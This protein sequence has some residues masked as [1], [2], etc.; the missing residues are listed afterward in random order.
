[1]SVAYAQ[2]VRLD[3]V[4]Q[5]HDRGYVIIPGIMPRTKVEA[6]ASDLKDRFARTPFCE[7]EFYGSHT[8]RF[9]GLLKRSPHAAAFVQNAV[10]MD[11]AQ[12]ILGPITSAVLSV[13]L[14]YNNPPGNRQ[15]AISLSL[16]NYVAVIV[17]GVLLA[18]AWVMVEAT[19]IADDHAAIV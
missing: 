11:I 5:I 19:R 12:A 13:A 9:G 6:L 2:P 17:G 3:W 14:T 7:G 8:K 18:V 1:M 15:L 10:I 16:D 4:Q